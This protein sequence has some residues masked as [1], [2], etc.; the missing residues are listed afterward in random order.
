M[1]DSLIEIKNN[2]QGN[3]SKVDEAENE[4]NWNIRQQ[5]QT[6]TKQKDPVRNKRY[7]N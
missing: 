1:K 7:T 2:L 4:I 6:K 5:K 3:N